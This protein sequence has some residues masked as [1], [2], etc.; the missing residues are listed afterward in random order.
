MKEFLRDYGVEFTKQ[1]ITQG[2]FQENAMKNDM[3]QNQ[4]L[5]RF[6]ARSKGGEGGNSELEL[7][8]IIIAIEAANQKVI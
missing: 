2:E 1:G 7:K 3:L 4:P 5:F 6:S 8:D